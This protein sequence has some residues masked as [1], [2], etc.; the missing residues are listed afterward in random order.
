M[1]DE[2]D[3]LAN[4]EAEAEHGRLAAHHRDRDAQE[5]RALAG[6]EPDAILTA[7]EAEVDAELRRL[8][9][10][11]GSLRAEGEAWVRLCKETVRLRAQLRAG[12]AQSKG[13]ETA[14][15]PDHARRFAS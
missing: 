15:Q 2:Y 1:T 7:S 10:D 9:V 8:G 12:R 3:R 5:R 6:E 13:G 4:R 14:R 11:P